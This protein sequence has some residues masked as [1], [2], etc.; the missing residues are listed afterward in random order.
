MFE[1]VKINECL[2]KMWTYRE[3][4]PTSIFLNDDDDNDA[5]LTFSC[6]QEGV[7]CCL[8]G[9]HKYFEV[10]YVYVQVL[11]SLYHL[12]EIHTPKN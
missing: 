5:L 6:F 1:Y 8:F 2:L 11:S 10:I 3:A 7:A 12:Q 4:M 9:K